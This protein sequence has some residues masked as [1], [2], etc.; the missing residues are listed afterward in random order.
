[1]VMTS[2]KWKN[3]KKKRKHTINGF[4]IVCVVGG[5]DYSI[6][7]AS[8]YLYLT[9]QVKADNPSLFYGLI[10][11]VYSF[12]STIFG[13]IC[14]ILIDKYR[15]MRLYTNIT[16]L[17]QII[18]S[19]IYVIPFSPSYL[20][21]GRLIAG[22]GDTFSSTSTGETVRLFDTH[23]A[24]S[25]IWK[26]AAAYSVGF[27]LG[28]GIGIIFKDIS[29]D[30]WLIHVE[31]TNFVGIFIAGLLLIA[32]I[33]ANLLI[34]D[35]SLEFD[36]KEYLRENNLEFISDD[37]FDV[38]FEQD[39]KAREKIMNS[40]L[41][42]KDKVK[43]NSETTPLLFKQEKSTTALVKALLK[44]ANIVFI[45][46]SS[47]FFMHSLFAFDVLL[48]LVSLELL[49]WDITALTIILVASAILYF[50]A[51]MLFSKFCT[52][53]SGVYNMTIICIL[54]HL[55]EFGI[56]IAMKMVTR[57]LTKNVTLMVAFLICYIFVWFIEEVL[58]RSILAQMVPS[59]VQS[60]TESIR[61]GF[62]RASTVVASL[63]APAALGVLHY[64]S[65]ALLGSTVI[66]L[67]I[68]LL[69][70]K[71]LTHIEAIRI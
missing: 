53:N 51:L 69:K 32:L 20:L 8:L 27:A 3:W 52:S 13:L 66:F 10:I 48:P 50:F 43:L 36:L 21:V 61:N 47:F 33:A 56:L 40:A 4:L 45:F 44:N 63:T 46:I 30:I 55:I 60:F 62:S 24:T 19:L 65:V 59:Q 18:G 39:N 11:A 29:F 41:I 54:L 23:Q 25:N 31:Y 57:N 70:K 5:M 2:A 37:H 12:S 9:T 64:W 68:F 6:V 38:L 28:P 34:H 16:L 42:Q 67:L 14:G 22:A 15:K 35:C 17:L 1:M 7:F 71:Q 26:I 49:K 58:L